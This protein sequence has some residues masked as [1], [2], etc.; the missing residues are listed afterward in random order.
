M[1]STTRRRIVVYLVITVLPLSALALY[2]AVDERAEDE[3]RARIEEKAIVHEVRTDLDRLFHLSR[4]LVAGIGDQESDARICGILDAM[5]RSFPEFFNLGLYEVREPQQT[6]EL[7]C[8][9][10][11]PA[12]DK[13]PLTPE[14]TQLLTLL[15]KRGDIVVAPIRPNIFDRKPVI[16]V[17]GLVTTFPNGV[18]RL[19][20][21]TVSLEWLN[22]Q[23]NRLAIPEKAVLLVLDRQ[24]IIAAR[25]P[26]SSEW[27]LGK[28]APDFERTLPA[29]RD[30]D[31]EI[32]GEYGIVRYYALA[33]VVSADG[34]VVVLK[35]QSAQ[36]FRRSRQRLI[37]HLAGLFGIAGLV[38][39]VAWKN[40]ETYI[41]R[42]LEKLC[43]AADRLAS[44]N[45][46]GRSGLHYR[47]EIGRVAHSFDE[48][49]ASL[50]REEIRN[51]QMLGSLRALRAR[52]ESV[53]EEERTRIAREI[54]DELGQ[55]L[56]A[57]HFELS[58]LSHSLGDS[59]Q[60]DQA[61]DLMAMTDKAIRQVRKIAT[62]L[63]PV[64]LDYGG[65]VEAVDWLA[66]DFQRRTGVTCIV[67][68]PAR[69]E[70]SGD[71]A[72]C[73]FR[74][75]QESLTNVTRHAQA[76]EVRISLAMN[77][78]WYTLTVRDN[79]RG[80]EPAMSAQDGSL[81]ILG[82]GERARITG[83]SLKIA[84]APGTGTTVV[85]RIPKAAGYEPPA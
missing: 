58:R 60:A 4:S 62:E 83:G 71:V 27:A 45:L 16:P 51:N 57:M 3:A 32:V 80:F 78:G 59:P 1:L 2:L 55:Q 63:R 77:D 50:E 20:A 70:A 61:V 67:D 66:R 81:G 46:T 26:V 37:V 65:L 35:M 23:V 28:P 43:R 42:P 64:A 6:G 79:G 31:D 15:R 41:A 68:A 73:L 7:I 72:I 22:E 52:L 25:N 74:I 75:C 21:A 85:A 8:S 39:I 33:H 69:M 24:G 84:S 47:G 17:A 34:M 29:R 12:A 14:E 18:R 11:M 53:S 49:A 56:T 5:H 36:I 40:S 19:V 13:F 48:M 30:F 76:T 38:F 54:H 10:V 82:M 9:A 44:G